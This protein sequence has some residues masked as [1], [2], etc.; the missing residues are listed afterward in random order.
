MTKI[1]IAASITQLERA[2]SFAAELT[3]RGHAIVSSWHAGE[4]LASSDVGLTQSQRWSIAR[5]AM[6]EVMMCDALLLLS[7]KN[8]QGSL[9]EAGVAMGARKPVIAIGNPIDFTPM[10]EDL[11]KIVW[12]V[13]K[14]DAFD[15]LDLVKPEPVTVVHGC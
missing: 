5:T 2:K 3:S 10:L 9:V 14:D 4:L 12:F 8:G 1:Y 11:R 15:A 7:N 6:D 13:F